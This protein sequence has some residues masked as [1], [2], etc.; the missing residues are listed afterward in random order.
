MSDGFSFEVMEIDIIP[1]QISIQKLLLGMI[2]FLWPG[3]EPL[4]I[5]D[6]DLK[7]DE[8]E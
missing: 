6:V 1:V 8:E 2:E 3:L 5:H 4:E 7:E